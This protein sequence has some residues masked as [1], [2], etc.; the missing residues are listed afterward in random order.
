M[1]GLGVAIPLM[2]AG[3]YTLSSAIVAANGLTLVQVI[4][5]K[6]DKHHIVYSEK[7]DV[8]KGGCRIVIVNQGKSWNR[9][10]RI[11]QDKDVEQWTEVKCGD[12][13]GKI[14]RT[15][16]AIKFDNKRADFKA[17]KTMYLAIMKP[18]AFGIWITE[19]GILIP[20]DKLH[21]FDGKTIYVYF[22]DAG[23]KFFEKA[24]NRLFMNK[25]T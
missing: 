5:N 23:D 7:P 15:N 25:L 4:G 11:Y 24:E 10:V 20:E 8:P 6:D 13:T 12:S 14:A 18:A 1:A 3:L 9:A 2:M 19:G 17:G 16:P 22:D 21:E